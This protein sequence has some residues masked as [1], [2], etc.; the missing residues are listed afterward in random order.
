MFSFKIYPLS[1]V[2]GL[3]LCLQHL[4]SFTFMKVTTIKKKNDGVSIFDTSPTD[5]SSPSD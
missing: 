2:L 5:I 1:H 3:L 4:Q